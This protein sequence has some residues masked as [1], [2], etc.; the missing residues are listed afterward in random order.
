MT[1]PPLTLEEL[2]QSTLQFGHL[3]HVTGSPGSGKTSFA[4]RAA[5][6][7][8]SAGLPVC[9]VDPER[10]ASAYLMGH[11][12]IKPGGNFALVQSAQLHQ[13][14]DV[15]LSFLNRHP[16]G[17]LIL[18]DIHR[19][20]THE[21]HIGADWERTLNP[22]RAS[23][24]SVSIVALGRGQ[25]VFDYLADRVIRLTREREGF[26]YRFTKDQTGL[27]GLSGDFTIPG[28]SL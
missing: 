27:S 8:L 7:A 24:S 15:A 11:M 4:L 2:V 18:D 20:T 6:L 13:I 14:R 9:Y 10:V 19:C 16:F 28:V 22:L 23:M 26:G 1:I 3:T 21:E 25:R 17:L 5:S 12:G